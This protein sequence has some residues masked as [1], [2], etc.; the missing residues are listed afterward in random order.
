LKVCFFVTIKNGNEG[1]QARGVIMLN[2]K[3]NLLKIYELTPKQVKQSISG[4][5]M[6]DKKTGAIYGAKII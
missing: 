6:A 3:K 1:G 5:G 4:Y 2:A